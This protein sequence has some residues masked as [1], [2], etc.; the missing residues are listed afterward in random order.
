[1]YRIIRREFCMSAKKSQSLVPRKAKAWCQEK[2]KGAW[3]VRA[4]QV[5]ASCVTSNGASCVTW[6]T[7]LLCDMDYKLGLQACCGYRLGI[8]WV[9][10]GSFL[11][12]KTLWYASS[13]FGD[14]FV[15]LVCTRLFRLFGMHKT[16]WS[17][18]Y[19]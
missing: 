2:P 17:L 9:S 15:S 10:T 14:S 4:Y 12:H 8:D 3:H 13:L 1:M 7:S 11:C 16:L 19:A 5:G 6:T 18:W